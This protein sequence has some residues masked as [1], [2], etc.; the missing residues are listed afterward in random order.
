MLGF[1]RKGHPLLKYW[2]ED[3]MR[4]LRGMRMHGI[5]WRRL[6]AGWNTSVG[7]PSGPLDPKRSYLISLLRMVEAYTSPASG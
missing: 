4:P 2:Y 5:I 7:P 3:S 1:R 6:V